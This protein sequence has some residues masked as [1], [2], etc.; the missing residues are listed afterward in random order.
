MCQV[1][2]D[3]AVAVG[4]VGKRH[5]KQTSVGKR[6]LHTRAKGVLVVL[7]FYYGQR[8]A[9]LLIEHIVGPEL[10]STLIHVVAA[11]LNAAV[12]QAHLFAQLAVYVP[13]GPHDGRRDELGPD[14]LLGQ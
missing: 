8:Y 12:G 4:T 2:L 11:H 7:G 1:V 3:E 9:G 10:G 13:T 14:I 5:V 6:L